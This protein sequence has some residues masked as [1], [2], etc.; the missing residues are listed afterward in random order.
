MSSFDPDLGLWHNQGEI[1]VNAI[2]K[3]RKREDKLVLRDFHGILA[4]RE[5]DAELTILDSAAIVLKDRE[6]GSEEWLF[7]DVP[8]LKATDDK[9]VVLRSGESLRKDFNA[10]HR[11]WE[12]YE[13]VLVVNGYYVP[14]A[15]QTPS[16]SQ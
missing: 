9:V 12:K 6:T 14:F 11:D 2:G 15:M 16:A 8:E 3:S 1:L 13:V 4:I 5:E 10:Y 7:F